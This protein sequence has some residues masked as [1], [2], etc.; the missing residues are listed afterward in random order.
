MVR[1]A[2]LAFGLALIAAASAP[3]EIVAH[4]V[5]D[6][7]LSLG[8]TGSP[9]VAYVKGG[10][11][12]VAQRS[13]SGGWSAAKADSVSP[14]TKLMDFQVG[15]AG[16]VA[17]TLSADN[18]RLV[19][20][21]RLLVG[22]QR[23]RIE[24]SLPAHMILGWPGLT[25]DPHGLPYVGYT[26]WRPISFH[27]RLLVARVDAAG[28]VTKQ[29]ITAEGFPQSYAPPP[30][31]PVL[32]G[33]Q[34][35]VIQAYGYRGVI[36]TLEW[37]RQKHTWIGFG[38][39]AGLGDFPIGAVFA[40]V[41]PSRHVYAAWTDS[42]DASDAP[43]T[44]AMRASISITNVILDRA[45]TTGIALPSSGP[46]VAANEWVSSVDLGLGGS[47]YLW[48][49][50]IARADGSHVQ[51]D[52]WLD[53]LAV[54]PRGG[55]EVLLAGASGLSWFQA[56]RRLTTRVSVHADDEGDGAVKVSGTVSGVSTG[57]VAVYR[58]RPGEAR[59]LVGRAALS[60]GSFSVL[61]TPTMRPLV[62]RAVY[63]DPATGIPYAALLRE[64]V[65]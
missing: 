9:Y 13:A 25:L 32:V 21:R 50:T 12:I 5:R 43:V 41:G 52:G 45:L 10:S 55:R 63:T 27:S 53:G 11:L 56:P 51:L 29:Q 33:G 16:P 58:E 1:A 2:A 15:A 54:A 24:G 4:G 47:K 19:L 34:V 8:P 40:E 42:F 6:G 30:A 31:K 62:Y 20:V 60:G 57:R 36:G 46:E 65:S 18:R 37:F 23:I 48:A 26:R 35:H 14:G 44:L 64:P 3:A 22:W 7:M 61:D 39:D 38:L 49:G 28:R 17:I 59:L